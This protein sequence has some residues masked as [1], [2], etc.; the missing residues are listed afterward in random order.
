MSNG[1]ISTVGA[2]GGMGTTVTYE[3][4]YNQPCTKADAWKTIVQVG[5]HFQDTSGSGT[6]TTYITIGG[7]A[8]EYSTYT[9]EYEMFQPYG[10]GIFKFNAF[11]Y[12]KVSSSQLVVRRAAPRNP[13]FKIRRVPFPSSTTP[14]RTPHTAGS[15]LGNLARA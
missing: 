14:S 4:E 8:T 5:H 11:D 3:D 2:V 9:G 12:C 13:E 10:E 1:R 6:Q 7:R 15:V